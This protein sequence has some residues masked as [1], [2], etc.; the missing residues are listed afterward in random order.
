[1]PEG[2]EERKKP[3]L[4]FDTM[5]LSLNAIEYIYGNKSTHD[6]KQYQS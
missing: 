4:W 6:E 3:S 2:A 1:M 5:W